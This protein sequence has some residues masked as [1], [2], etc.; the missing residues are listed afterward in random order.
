M[1]G[2]RGLCGQQA[3]APMRGQGSREAGLPGALQ[4]SPLPTTAP[5]STG[6]SPISRVLVSSSCGGSRRGHLQG[7]WRV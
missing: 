2:K 3:A 6:A 1:A 7:Q 5:A 4:E